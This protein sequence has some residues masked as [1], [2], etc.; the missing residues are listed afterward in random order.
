MFSPMYTDCRQTFVREMEA[1]MS[2]FEV[3]HHSDDNG[4]EYWTPV[5]SGVS[6]SIASPHS[7]PLT[8]NNRLDPSG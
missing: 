5:N 3:I 8:Q 6:S 2:P 7:F 4:Q 1:Y